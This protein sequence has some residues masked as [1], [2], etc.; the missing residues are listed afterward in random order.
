M[1]DVTTASAADAP[2]STKAIP[3]PVDAVTVDTAVLCAGGLAMAR[4]A[5]RCRRG[6]GLQDVVDSRPV[7]RTAPRVWPRQSRKLDRVT[8]VLLVA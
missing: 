7:W 6:V 8:L 4:C 1:S 5:S 3:I 2:R